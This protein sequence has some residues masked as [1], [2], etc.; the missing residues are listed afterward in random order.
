MTG[1]PPL[2]IV[3]MGTPVEVA[4]ILQ[5][6]VEM[7][8]PPIAVVTQGDKARGRGL[9]VSGSP[10]KSLAEKLHIPV[11]QPESWGSPESV[12]WLKKQNPDAVLIAAYGHILP[13]GILKIPRLGFFNVHA[14]LLPKFRG[15]EPVRWAI[16]SG[17][18]ETGVTFFQLEGGVDAGPV[19][20]Q[21]HLPIEKN[22]DAGILT[23][24][25]FAH[26]A[27]LLPEFLQKIS[28]PKFVPTP[29]SGDP[30]PR[31][32]KFTNAES[33]IM[34]KSPAA[35]LLL[36]IRAMSPEP[37][38]FTWMEG[39]RLRVFRAEVGSEEV[40]HPPG[41]IHMVDAD[42]GL[43][44]STSDKVL[45]LRELQLEGRKR[46]PAPAFLQGQKNIIPLL[47]LGTAE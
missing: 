47:K 8:C 13:K 23:Q 24:K 4:I 44:V 45:W 9:K 17:E 33:E 39:K 26:A 15:A 18:K 3:F 46:L 11:F 32:R 30:G 31:A 43:G 36:H 2:R 27:E 42:K 25:I 5:K 20:I 34:W 12:D 10:V 40:V 1:A 7:A 38:A 16:L 6:M 29:Q 28:T 41:T 14:S 19:V 21:S 22:D 35:K 37:G